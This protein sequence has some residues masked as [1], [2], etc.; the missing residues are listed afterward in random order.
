M[1]KQSRCIKYK[2]KKLLRKKSNQEGFHITA[3]QKSLTQQN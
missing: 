1:L 3:S 2:H